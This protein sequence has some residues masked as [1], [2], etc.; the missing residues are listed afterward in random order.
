VRGPVVVRVYRCFMVLR[1]VGRLTRRRSGGRGSD[2]Q[3]ARFP[4][5][6]PNPTDPEVLSDWRLF[7]VL[8]TWMEEDVVE[9][10]VANAFAQGVEAVYLVD[11]A[12]TD[13]TVARA[14]A[15]GAVLA[16]SYR[17]EVYEERVRMLL[18]NAVVARVSLASEAAHIW[19]LWLD[20][21][22]FPEGPDG[23]TV[24]DYVGSLDRR[25]RLVGST[26]YNHFPTG[27]PQYIS[28]FHPIDFQD[29]CERFVPDQP[30][31]CEQPHWKHPLQRFDR[32]G[33]FL[34]SLQGFH[35]ATL[36]M[37][38]RV[39]EPVGGI[40]THHFPY[41]DEEVTRKRMEQLCGGANRNGYND[42]I[43][44][45]SIKKRFDTLDAV[46]SGRWDSVDSLQTRAARAGV[47]PQ[48]WPDPSSSRRWYDADQ[49]ADARAA[50]LAAAG[51]RDRSSEA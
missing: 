34:S 39:T 27:T 47:H 12:S 33:P 7:A 5:C 46:Y 10:T 40:V 1:T 25:F 9:A 28:G 29:L 43:G 38:E 32:R 3:G 23:R 18:M 6:E 35:G 11:N 31:Y 17:T 26:Y 41:R 14:E 44:N 30:G 13:G 51:S 2:R 37:G 36:L 48:P 22:E 21:D 4:L 42:A 16:E 24:A 8:G 49:L 15:A 20:A 50:W 45:S 19:W